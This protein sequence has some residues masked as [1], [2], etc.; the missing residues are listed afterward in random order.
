M[1]MGLQ[2]NSCK[3]VLVSA[4]LTFSAL[5]PLKFYYKQIADYFLI[6]LTESLVNI[7]R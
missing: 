7:N 5:T 3:N 1:M 4:I 2:V 6:I